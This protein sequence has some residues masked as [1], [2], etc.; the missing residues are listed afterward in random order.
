MEDWNE[1]SSD[2]SVLTE[3]IVKLGVSGCEIEEVYS[4]EN[5][6]DSKQLH[7]LVLLSTWNPL[8][9]KE[10]L[11]NDPEVFILSLIDPKLSVV[12]GILT[13]LL[14]AEVNLSPDLLAFQT[15][16][17][18]LSSKLKSV[19]LHNSNFIRTVN[20]SFPKGPVK[21]NYFFTC[22]L[23]VKGKVLEIDS[24]GNGPIYLGSE[25]DWIERARHSIFERI[26][27]FKEHDVKYTLLAITNNQVE[28][29]KKA[30]R[31]TDTQIA[32]IQKKM[33]GKVAE[34]DAEYL[35]SLPEDYQALNSEL[36]S[37]E[38]LKA[39]HESLI[40]SGSSPN[41]NWKKE[42]IRR[43][44]NYIPFILALLKKL[45]KDQKLSPL[46]DQALKKKVSNSECV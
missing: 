32:T 33:G 15:L 38:E 12:Q 26:S 28:A 31:F 1:I 36:Q 11:Y 4:L 3:F 39:H 35:E 29:S 45:E 7:G 22:F 37:I 17:A 42:E 43:K 9:I 8:P 41:V 24:L 19:A 13:V 25:E 18:P 10:G 27:A 6:E 30:I 2:P 21:E 34:F 20:N 14:N 46:L 5:L 44:H 16:I 23:P 40:K